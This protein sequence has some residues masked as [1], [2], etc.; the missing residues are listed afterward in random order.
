MI[1]FDHD[2]GASTVLD[3][4]R[5]FI[6]LSSSIGIDGMAHLQTVSLHF[7]GKISWNSKWDE[8]DLVQA[9]MKL[10]PTGLKLETI[11]VDAKVLN[12]FRDGN[13]AKFMRAMLEKAAQLAYVLEAKGTP[14]DTATVSRN[15]DAWKIQW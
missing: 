6:D 7:V 2:H 9:M 8:I 13:N 14:A 1:V 5:S 12:T 15:V 3:I 4:S 10:P 11:S